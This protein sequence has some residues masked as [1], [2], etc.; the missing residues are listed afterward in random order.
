MQTSC[1]EPQ[2]CARAHHAV[3]LA[4]AVITIS[5]HSVLVLSTAETMRGTE[6]ESS[7]WGIWHVAFLS[8][9]VERS[10]RMRDAASSILAFSNYWY[11][12]LLG[13]FLCQ[14]GACA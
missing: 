11:C 5:M 13:V 7:T 14:F 1:G 6:N 2:G 9:G 3:P 10:L 12:I 4:L 8:S